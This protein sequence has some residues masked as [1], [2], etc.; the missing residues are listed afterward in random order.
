MSTITTEIDLALALL[1][2][3]EIVAIPTE[4]VYGLAGN[5]EMSKPLENLCTKNRL[6]HPLIMHVAENWIYL[7]G[8][9]YSSLC[10][11]PNQT[12]LARPTDPSHVEAKGKV[13]P[14]IT[15]VRQCC[16]YAV[17]L[18]QLLKPFYNS[19]VFSSCPSATLL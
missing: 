11:N 3:G 17:L 7:T 19:L 4:T 2:Q 15:G 13:S 1:K 16:F 6:N 12:L 9:L 18:I 14:L 10:T 5:A 8:I